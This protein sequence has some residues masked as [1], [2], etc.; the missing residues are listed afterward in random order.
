MKTL[1]MFVSHLRARLGQALRSLLA[2]MR[3]WAPRP[4]PVLVPIPIRVDRRR[5]ESIQRRRHPGV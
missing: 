1:P 5:H 4:A 2:A 3:A